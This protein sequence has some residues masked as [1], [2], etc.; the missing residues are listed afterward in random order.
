MVVAGGCGEGGMGKRCGRQEKQERRDGV[1]LGC[2]F[3]AAE[4]RQGLE[5]K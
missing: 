3:P 2:A 4:V 5:C 1:V